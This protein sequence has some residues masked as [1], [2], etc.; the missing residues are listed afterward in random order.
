MLHLPC[1]CL[2]KGPHGTAQLQGNREALRSVPCAVC[3]AALMANMK[4][5]TS[6][7]HCRISCLFSSCCSSGILGLCLPWARVVRF[8]STTVCH[9]LLAQLCQVVSSSILVHLPS[10]LSSLA[11]LI[12]LS[13]LPF[14][15]IDI[16]LVWL[17]KRP[18]FHQAV[19]GPLPWSASSLSS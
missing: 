7:S 6:F 17:Q 1:P 11:A 8:F 18:C 9:F 19:T 10:C 3:D 5:L 14:H 15:L 4:C 13:T 12:H 2:A 16:E